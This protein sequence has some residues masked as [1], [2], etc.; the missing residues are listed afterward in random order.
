ML[1]PPAPGS[2]P[3]PS[4]ESV[5]ELAHEKAHSA[6]MPLVFYH[7][8]CVNSGIDDIRIRSH[9][10]GGWLFT[11]RGVKDNKIV[12]F[13]HHGPEGQPFALHAMMAL[14]GFRSGLHSHFPYT[15]PPDGPGSPP[16][17]PVEATLAYTQEDILEAAKNPVAVS[18]R[19]PLNM[20]MCKQC[21]NQPVY[22]VSA[23]FCGG[24]CAKQWHIAATAK[25]R[26]VKL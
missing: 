25:A 13:E 14:E 16:M 23:E 2:K 21:K 19:K 22:N 18:K 10:N 6:T 12:E 4:A 17:T 15:P 7:A 1:Q 5:Q 11:L 26:G 24:E 20:P 8:M 3:G 9:P